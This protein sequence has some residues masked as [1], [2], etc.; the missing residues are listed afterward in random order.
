MKEMTNKAADYITNNSLTT[1]AGGA[2]KAPGPAADVE[3]PIFYSAIKKKRNDNGATSRNKPTTIML[4]TY[5][6]TMNQADSDIMKGVLEGLGFRVLSPVAGVQFDK[7]RDPKLKTISGQQEADVIILNTCTVKGPTENKIIERIRKLETIRL[8]T[9]NPKLVLCG[10]MSANIAKI[11]KYTSAPIVWPGAI[12]RI[13][14]AVE[15]ALEGRS[16]EYKEMCDKGTLPRVF[17]KPILRIGIAEGC[18]GTCTFCQ[19]K[20]ARPGLRSVK[21]PRIIEWMNEGISK[22][23]KEIQLTAMDAGAY[24]LDIKSDLPSLLSCINNIEGDFLVRLGMINPE[25]VL[26]MKNQLI[27][28]MKAK[29]IYKFLHIPVQSGSEKVVKEMRRKHTVA[30]FEQIVS[31]FRKAIPEITIATDI[32]VGYPSETQ[33][34]FSKTLNLLGRVRPDVVNLS[35][36]SP[37]PGTKAKELGQLDN[38]VIKK[39]SVEA[40]ALVK[41]ILTENNKKYIGREVEVL[42]TEKQK[43]FT[44]RTINYKQ[45]VVKNFEGELGEKVKIKIV[46]ANHGSLF[47]FMNSSKK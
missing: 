26:R 8:K 2:E 37:R 18:T 7:T 15:D 13:G 16:T 1:A 36:F 12:N 3:R 40:S 29:H 23:A 24:G 11:R 34:D 6:C 33:D 47:G 39:R 31:E 25:H 22:G 30:E 42:I 27:D 4:E 44:G 38:G 19:T 10:C 35:K 45:V 43:S 32:I 14:N 41:E 28:A 9:G 20:L 46:D 5:G 21:I 17:T